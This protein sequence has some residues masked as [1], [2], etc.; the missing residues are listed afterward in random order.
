MAHSEIGA[1]SAHRWL[2]CPGSVRLYRQLT[3]RK[4]TIF[5]DM[6]TAAHE[7]AEGCFL[8]NEDPIACLGN[9]VT[10]N[11]NTITIDEKIVRGVG[12]YVDKVRSDLAEFGGELKVEQSFSLEWLYPGMFGRNDACIVPKEHFG[13]LRVYDYKNGSKNV[14]AKNNPQMMYYA[15]GAL[16]EHNLSLAETVVL[17]IVQP[18]TWVKDPIDSWEISVP[19]LYAWG[20]DVLLPAAKATQEPNA[21]CISGDWCQFCEASHLCPTRTEEALAKLDPP[22]DGKLVASLPDPKLISV[23][24]LGAMVSFFTSP[25]FETWVKAITEAERDLFNRG[26]NIPG[27]KMITIEKLSNRKWA[28]ETEAINVLKEYGDE[29]W[30]NELKSPAQIEKVLLGQGLK[31]TQRDAIVSALTTRDVTLTNIVVDEDDERESI[32]SRND[33]AIELFK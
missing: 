29:I 33:R 27:R 14:L 15:L 20:H 8:T 13:T 1:S 4:S 25:Q 32:E 30:V 3:E 23:D 28:N 12:I 7:L 10:I 26:V 22:K 16:G 5:A 6:G 19:D 24:K 9:V 18:N 31:K 11:D 17:T 21:P 2:N